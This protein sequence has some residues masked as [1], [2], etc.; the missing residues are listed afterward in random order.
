MEKEKEREREK[1][2]E[3]K[4]GVRELAILPVQRVMR[5]VL[6]YRGECLWT[7]LL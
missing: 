3:K 4:P 1:E 7:H 5:Y 2:K 6:Q